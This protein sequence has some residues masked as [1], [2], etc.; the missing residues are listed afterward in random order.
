MAG[1]FDFAGFIAK[2]GLP[3][4]AA[5]ETMGKV[6][7]DFVEIIV[8]DLFMPGLYK[9]C[10]YIAGHSP[11]SQKKVETLFRSVKK[12]V[13]VVHV[14]AGI[15]KFVLAVV[16]VYLVLGIILNKIGNLSKARS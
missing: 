6:A 13:D 15:L 3:V 4:L 14:F 10:V 8:N 12:E 9:G 2:N 5:G 7:A 1:L 11:H 16:A